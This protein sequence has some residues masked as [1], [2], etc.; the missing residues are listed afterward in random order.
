VLPQVCGVAKVANDTARGDAVFMHN[1]NWDALG[2][3]D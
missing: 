2:V 3:E 1:L